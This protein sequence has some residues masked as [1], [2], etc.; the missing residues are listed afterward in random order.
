[1]KRRFAL[2]LLPVAV[3]SAAAGCG[4][5]SSGTSGARRTPAAASATASVGHRP[6]QARHRARRRHADA[7]S[8][9]SRRTRARASS[10]YGALRERLAAAHHERTGAS[11]AAACARPSSARPKRT[12]RH[13]R[14]HL[15]RAPALHLRGRRAS[16]A[17]CTGRAST[18]S[19][20]SGTCSRRAATR[21]T[22]TRD[23]R[24]PRTR[25]DRRALL[26]ALALLG[27]GA[28]AP[29]RSTPTTHYSAIP[30]IGTLF[31]LNFVVRDADRLR[32]GR[33]RPAPPR[34]GRPPRAAAGVRRWDRRRRRVAR[35]AAAQRA[36]RAV[37]LHG[38]R[39]PARD[40]ALDRARGGNGR[41]ARRASHG[42]PR[43]ALQRPPADP[44]SIP[45]YSRAH[46]LPVRAARVRRRLTRTGAA[47]VREARHARAAGSTW[48]APSRRAS[49]SPCSSGRRTPAPSRRP[50]SRARARPRR[51][52]SPA[53]P[54]RAWS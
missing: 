35:G 9:C 23:V 1:M 7:R 13:A 11:P 42:A 45:R 30:T 36:R 39:L 22:A 44:A 31:A 15:R 10:C 50:A 2:G 18:S 16:P 17:T 43:A 51:A 6:H 52:A 20:P 29:R 34:A 48:R 12:R 46:G 5:S 53:S 41:P 47:E 4:T 24:R 32:R 37:R 3:A 19:A 21:S 27:V 38:D 8:T 33:A 25:R 28:R 54:R 49:P 26:G 14:G 40:R